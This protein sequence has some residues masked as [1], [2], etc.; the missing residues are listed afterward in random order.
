[1]SEPKPS[2]RTKSKEE[3]TDRPPSLVAS[4]PPLP[5]STLDGLDPLEALKVI[6]EFYDKLVD[7]LRGEKT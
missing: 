2:Q 1:M 5:P 4:G 3:P 6:G 7:S